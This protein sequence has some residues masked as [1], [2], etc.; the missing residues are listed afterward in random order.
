[1]T[2]TAT[3]PQVS[4]VFATK[5]GC[6]QQDDAQRR[7]LVE[8]AGRTA[9]FDHRNLMKLRKAVYAIDIE[10][11]L[12]EGA[13]GPD[14]EIIFICASEHC[15]VLSLLQVIAIKDLL[16]GAFVMLELNQIIHNR[17]YRAYA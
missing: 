17:L 1:M 9:S 6:V 3:L 4:E 12:L 14:V 15:Y 5:H 10:Q 7:W 8:F 13:H 2:V 11:R 16:E